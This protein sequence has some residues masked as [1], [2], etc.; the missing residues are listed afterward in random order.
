MILRTVIPALALLLA[1]GE[2][3]R[4][5]VHD[6]G[7]PADDT[8]IEDEDTAE[9]E[10]PT[11]ICNGVDDD[12]DG[13]VDE[14][15]AAL[16]WDADLAQPGW[17][18]GPGVAAVLWYVD[19]WSNG[20]IDR[21]ITTHLDT[22]GRI[23]E[24]RYHWTDGSTPDQIMTWRY[25]AD[26]HLTEQWSE[27]EE[28]TPYLGEVRTWTDGLLTRHESY[29]TTADGS[30]GLT[31]VW[32]HAYDGDGYRTST[33]ED[34]DGD[35]AVNNITWF[36]WSEDRLVE[37]REYYVVR[38]DAVYMVTRTTWSETGKILSHETDTDANGSYDTASLYTY[39]GDDLLLTEERDWSGD[40]VADYR[41]VHEYDG[42][43][44]RVWTGVD[45]DVDGA[46]DSG[47][48]W[49]WEGDSLLET[50]S[51]E[52]G[53][54]PEAQWTMIRYG[55]DAAGNT[56]MGIED[57]DDHTATGTHTWSYSYTCY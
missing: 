2:K 17:R 41:V 40:G 54:G 19:E 22:Q 5:P 44:R 42:G 39:D 38:L 8:G 21:E 33:E 50:L 28:G 18:Y 16:V 45:M 14:G 56:D 49:I 24:Q 48:G 27:D 31:M 52:D 26:G 9:P 1:C 32:D 23:Y 51:D 35:G 34:S 43:G 55:T 25:D 15:I 12:D 46:S 10:E 4:D 29:G 47:L 30:F 6:T 11:E 13:L 37:T 3:T 53:D 36:S 7:D 20:D 57:P